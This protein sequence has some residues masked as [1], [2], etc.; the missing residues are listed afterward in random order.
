VTRTPTPKPPP[1]PAPVTRVLQSDNTDPAE[2][3]RFVLDGNLKTHWETLPITPAS[4][5]FALDLGQSRQITRVRWYLGNREFAVAFRL[6][7]SDDAKQWQ[8]VANLSAGQNSFN[9]QERAVN[10]SGRYVR[11]YFTNPTKAT[12]LGEIGEAQVFVE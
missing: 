2:P 4:G 1:G 3:G 11:W 8:T 5:W 6:E 12:V 9:W 10:R 7:V